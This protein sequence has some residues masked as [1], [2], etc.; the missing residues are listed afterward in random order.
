M[1]DLLLICFEKPV[2]V[3][4]LSFWNT[5]TFPPF[6]WC[7]R[8][9]GLDL[10]KGGLSHEPRVRC[11]FTGSFRWEFLQSPKVTE[12]ETLAGL[13]GSLKLFNSGRTQPH[14]HIQFWY[15]ATKPRVPGW[16]RQL[17]VWLQLRSWSRSP[18]IKPYVGLPTWWAT[19][20]FLSPF[21]V[22]ALSLPSE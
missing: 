21:P 13:G 19:G 12:C 18:G 14:Y 6:L 17:S 11:S 5:L 15:K 8:T 10:L 1:A 3:K 4:F 22:N 2:A 20:L 9:H 7:P 16:L